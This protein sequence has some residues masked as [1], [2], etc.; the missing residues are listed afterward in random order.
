MNDNGRYYTHQIGDVSAIYRFN[1][2]EKRMHYMGVL[3]Y[4][5]TEDDIDYKDCKKIRGC[6]GAMYVVYR[7]CVPV[8][9]EA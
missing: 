1:S 2:E 4:C 8:E 3:D 7:V 5:L 6:S 9:V